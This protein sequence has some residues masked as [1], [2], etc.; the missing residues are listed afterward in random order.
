MHIVAFRLS[1]SFNRNEPPSTARFTARVGLNIGFCYSQ[2]DK[3]QFDIHI[4][5]FWKFSEVEPSLTVI[6]RVIDLTVPIVY[7]I[8]KFVYSL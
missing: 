7:S 8:M 6:N 5:A 4:T 1:V 2:F 3:N